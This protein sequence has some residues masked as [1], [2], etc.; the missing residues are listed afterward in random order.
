MVLH[1]SVEPFR[2]TQSLLTKYCGSVFGLLSLKL[3][4]AHEFLLTTFVTTTPLLASKADFIHLFFNL[5]LSFV[6]ISFFLHRCDGFR[7]SLNVLSLAPLVLRLF[8]LGVCE[9][10]FVLNDVNYCDWFFSWKDAFIHVKPLSTLSQV[11]KLAITDLVIINTAISKERW[12]VR[13]LQ[14]FEAAHNQIWPLAWSS[15]VDRNVTY[16]TEALIIAHLWLTLAFDCVI[17]SF[18]LLSFSP[19]V[20][21]C[22]DVNVNLKLHINLVLFKN[23]LLNNC[24]YFFQ[25]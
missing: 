5:A 3:S 18:C 4:I 7:S 17:S 24:I 6:L 1:S 8:I 15:H 2:R 13:K 21:L 12:S 23:I 14:S 22:Q 19:S 20:F 11:S 9:C 16:T 10:L 25:F